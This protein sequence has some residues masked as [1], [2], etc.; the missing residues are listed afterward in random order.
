MSPLLHCA[1]YSASQK[2]VCRLR[3]LSVLILHSSVPS[4]HDGVLHASITNSVSIIHIKTAWHQT[5][6]RPI[7]ILKYLPV[8]NRRAYWSFIFKIIGSR[9]IIQIMLSPPSRLWYR[10]VCVRLRITMTPPASFFSSKDGSSRFLRNVDQLLSGPQNI[11][12]FITTTTRT[13]NLGDVT[14]TDYSCWISNPLPH[15]SAVI[16]H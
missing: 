9:N 11:V 1:P 10:V 16:C 6:Q 15:G 8:M 2:F 13:S 12:I 3:I 4:V 5:E 14:I 7:L